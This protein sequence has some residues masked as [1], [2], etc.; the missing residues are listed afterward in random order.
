M[1]IISKNNISTWMLV[2]AMIVVGTMSRPNLLTFLMIPLVGCWLFAAREV[3]RREVARPLCK[4]CIV[5]AIA[6]SAVTVILMM[7]IN[8]LAL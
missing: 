5:I 3:A 6:V 1:D 8:W 2:A 7:K 4:T